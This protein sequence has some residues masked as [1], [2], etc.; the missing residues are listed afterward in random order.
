MSTTPTLLRVLSVALIIGSPSLGLA[1]EGTDPAWLRI[2][3]DTR[4]N[5]V[6]DDLATGGLGIEA[7]Q[8]GEKPG[9]LDPARPTA[10]ELRR[11]A[12]ANKGPAG[13]G[14]LYGPNIDPGTGAVLPGDGK[15][16]GREI[17]A[18]A[19]DGD[20]S[21][22]VV[23]MLQIPDRLERERPC[24]L[25]VPSSGS[26]GIYSDVATIGSWGLHRGCA[27]V[28]TDK[29]LG[30][31]FHDLERDRIHRIDGS[32]ADAGQ[33]GRDA[34]FRAL[35]SAQEQADF[36]R[37]KLHRIAF[38]HAHSQ[39]NP[40]ASWGRDVLRSI[41][42]ASHVLARSGNLSNAK[43]LVIVA[44]NSNGGGA[45]L[46]AGA[47]DET[48]LIDGLVA[49]E[50]QVQLRRDE[51]V[52][53]QRGERIRNGTGRTLLDYFTFGLLYQ[54][55]AAAATP[56]AP[57]RDR[58]PLAENR[59][60]SLIDRNLVEADTVADAATES[61]QRLRD[62]GWEPESDELHAA[63]YAIAPTATALKY[64]SSHGRF[65]VAEDVCGYSVASLDKE[66]RPQAMPVDEFARLFATAPGGAPA[67]SI[68]VLNDRDPGG[69]I[70]DSLSRSPGSQR[71]DYNLEGA[72]CLRE[73]AVG[74][75]PEA[76]RVRQGI[77]EMTTDANLRGTP[78]IIVHGR[79]DARVPIGFTSRPFLGLN[80]LSDPASNLR[81]YELANV[82]HFNAGL[83][84]HETR[85]VPITPYL[86]RSL[87][88]IHDHLSRGTPL[89]PSQLVRSAVAAGGPGKEGKG[90][91]L[92]PVRDSVGVADRIDVSAGRV[93]VPE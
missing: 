59:C 91:Q 8:R 19:D 22:N 48:G 62:Y 36:L 53:V 6:G 39:Q 90:L 87:D 76:V 68:D 85:F 65:S 92:P 58:V 18:Y 72:T 17:L 73:L 46:Y 52:S 9:F 69:A 26:N 86:W 24:L 33:A 74:D 54:P 27:V 60:Q 25:A 88:L 42:F 70:R 77:D 14:S 89:P 12:L 84:G 93:V 32:T 3:S 34:H 40:D 38:K 82:E 13:F 31:G 28:Y 50:P 37:R 78:T 57:M 15:V 29:G 23:L 64:V 1:A 10:P 43:P 66:G 41:D 61:L 35:L 44:G 4:Y 47:A 5:G 80:A 75:S 63:Q 79:A 21:Q 67:G 2:M 55:C 83:P 81:L 16:P 56:D 20:G 51:R 45:A 71:Q 11:L 49:S 7:L 30:N